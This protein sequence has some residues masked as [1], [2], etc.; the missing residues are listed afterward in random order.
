MSWF[1][2]NYEKAFLGGAAVIAA[3]LG[4]AVIGGGDDPFVTDSVSPDDDVSVSGVGRMEKVKKSLAD[5]HVI[6]EAD[7][8]GRKVNLF[9]GVAL[10]AK[11]NDAAKPVDLLK[12]D[13]VHPGIPNIWWLKYGLDPGYANSP[14]LDPDEDGFTNRE[15]HD[16]GTD[17]TDFKNHPNPV[18]KLVLVGRKRAQVHI[19][20]QEFGAGKYMFKL[21][22]K[23]GGKLNEM[24]QMK[25]QPI[26]ENSLIPFV[27][28][29]M[30]DRFKFLRVEK[31]RNERTGAMDSIWLFEDQKPSKKGDIYRFQRNGNL[32]GLR[33]RSRGILDTTLKLRLDAL[34]QGGNTFEVEEGTRFSLPF[35]PDAKDKPYLLKKIGWDADRAEVE[36]TDKEGNKK[37]HVMPFK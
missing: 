12:S 1:S 10:F 36:Y 18:H 27:H 2:E 31:V 29:F 19:K 22:S 8:D 37:T 20:P 13:P 15:E 16:A 5:T 9:T 34:K 32:P 35:D 24:N 14:D 28:P 3:G 6:H 33:D 7:M 21:E 25:P 23:G 11:K 30:K 26:G 17:P 4:Y